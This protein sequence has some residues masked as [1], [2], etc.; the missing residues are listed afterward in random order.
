MLKPTSEQQK[1]YP[2]LDLDVLTEKN[3]WWVIWE[4]IFSGKLRQ[5]ED[6]DKS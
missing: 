1:K 4:Y 2:I 6:I 5:P 3:S